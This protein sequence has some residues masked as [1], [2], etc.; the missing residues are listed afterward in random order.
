MFGVFW[1]VSGEAC[2]RCLEGPDNTR[3]S[4]EGGD[5]GVSEDME[6]KTPVTVTRGQ[7]GSAGLS[8]A[9]VLE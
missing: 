6:E 3:A 1:V 8:I 9:P 5:G 7:D 2:F 4:S